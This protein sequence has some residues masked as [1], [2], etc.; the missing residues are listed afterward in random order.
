MNNLDINREYFQA[1]CEYHYASLE[2]LAS[3]AEELANRGDFASVQGKLHQIEDVKKNFDPDAFAYLNQEKMRGIE[4]RIAR[5]PTQPQKERTQSSL[6]M[7]VIAIGALAVSIFL[8]PITALV[9]PVIFIYKWFSQRNNHQPISQQGEPKKIPL[10]PVI[11]VDLHNASQYTI[12]GN[13]PAACTF[14][15]IKGAIRI[16]KDFDQYID[17]IANQKSEKL[18]YLQR[19]I[20][21]EGLEFYHGALKVD[22]KLIQ[23]ADIEDVK[24][25]PVR[26]LPKEMTIQKQR[27]EFVTREE[28]KQK[29]Q[30]IV[31]HLFDEA[32][33]SAHSAL[34]TNSNAES[35][36]LI[37]KG[38]QM[39]VFDSHK[40]ELYLITGKTK[41]LEHISQKLRPYIGDFNTF[42]YALANF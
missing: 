20:L 19:K 38:D 11:K 24:K 4:G 23:G 29:L 36:S 33:N 32:Q 31:D 3:Q 2:G 17:L 39:I 37:S 12:E 16:N 8:F 1:A 7:R 21:Q 10:E 25:L 14:H 5:I 35:F 34:L 18:S 15:A 13:R 26:L 42:N 27:T 22:R 40:N 28:L 30:P 9:I 6:A 41:A